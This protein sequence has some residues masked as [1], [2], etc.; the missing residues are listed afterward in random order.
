MGI[1]FL[2]WQFIYGCMR[3]QLFV[4]KKTAGKRHA[5]IRAAAP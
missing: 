1:V 4:R 5:G 3:T 2:G